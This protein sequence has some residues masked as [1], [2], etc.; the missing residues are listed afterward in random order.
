MPRLLLATALAACLPAPLAAQDKRP[1]ILF[2]MADDHTQ[3]ALG[4]YKSWLGKYANTPNLDRL[5]KRGMLFKN[6]LVTNSICTPSRAAILTG[7]YS[8][9]NGVYTLADPIDPMRRHLA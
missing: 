9:K 4:A 2:I 8:H 6:A 3:Q 7:L 5:A 1:N